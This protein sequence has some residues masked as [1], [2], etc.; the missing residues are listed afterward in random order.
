MD[1]DDIEVM[2]IPALKFRP[3]DVAIVAIDCV[4]S[5][6]GLIESGLED[7]TRMLCQHANWKNERERV[8]LE[9]RESIE[10]IVEE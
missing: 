9:M 10:R 7:V 3:L 8:A 4:G 1:D 6:F 2:T 5:M